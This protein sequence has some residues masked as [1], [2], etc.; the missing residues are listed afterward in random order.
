MIIHVDMDAFYASVEERDNPELVG[1][2]LVV[3]GHP[4]GR[5]VVATANYE[6][7][8]YGIHSAMPTSTAVKLF[9]QLIILPPRG[10]VYAAEAARIRHIF[11]RYTPLIE[12]LSLDEAF[13][14]VAGSRKLH[15]KSTKIARRIKTEI[16]LEL[17]LVASV[18]IGPNKFIAKLASDHDKPDGFTVVY[19]KEV[20]AFLD[21]MQIER[22]WGIGKSTAAKLHELG[23]QTICDLRLIDVS[24]LIEVAGKYG[25]RFYQLAHGIDDRQVI[26]AGSAKSISHESTFNIDVSSI[27]SL[28]STLMMLVE[29]VAFRVREAGLCGRTIQLK[30]RYADFKTVTRS[31][32]LEQGID[33]TALIWQSAQQLL[34]KT[35]ANKIF[36]IRLIGIGISNFV[37]EKPQ[38]DMFDDLFDQGCDPLD[39]LTDDINRRFGHHSI[40]RGKCI[41]KKR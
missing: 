17:R 30:L 6:A 16:Q 13:L 38:Q 12:P 18:G 19:P 21:P 33:T 35:L 31:T 22:I 39:Q 1:H 25:L 7:R 14:D 29:S 26:T 15:G 32:T 2:P 10:S 5:G 3:G 41:N 37:D 4:E 27:E 36:S 40:T 11:Q 34:H 24:K 8:R 28:E 20:Q 23:I 9:P